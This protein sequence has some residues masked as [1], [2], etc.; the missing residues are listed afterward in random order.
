VDIASEVLSRLRKV[1]KFLK[2]LVKV[3]VVVIKN[4]LPYIITETMKRSQEKG[5]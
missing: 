1:F 2:I 4:A 3:V 5:K